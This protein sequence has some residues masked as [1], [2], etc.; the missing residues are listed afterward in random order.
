MKKLVTFVCVLLLSSMSF[1]GEVDLFLEN[2]G[3]SVRGLQLELCGDF[4]PIG[5]DTLG[6][7]N[8]FACFFG[9]AGE[10]SVCGIYSI[11]GRSIP[12]GANAI[13][14]LH[15]EGE[16][17]QITEVEIYDENIDD[18]DIPGDDGNICL[19][20][21]LVGDVNFDG[22]VDIGEVIKAINRYLDGRATIAYVIKV[23][24]SYLGI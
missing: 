8:G 11:M 19:D 3:D 6:R 16:T 21:C 4:E 9:D 22:T 5:C 20:Y 2:P 10:C 12:P 23:I 14:T 24:N 13:A 1:A 17:P 18:L 15:Y 7:A